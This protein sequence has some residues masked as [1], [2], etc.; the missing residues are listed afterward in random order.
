MTEPMAELEVRGRS[1]APIVETPKA[2]RRGLGVGKVAR[3]LGSGS[4]GQ[5]ALVMWGTRLALFV[6]V[7]GSWQL[8]ASN[9]VID[10]SFTGQPNEILVRFWQ[11]IVHGQFLGQLGFTLEATL[12][13]FGLGS[14]AAVLFAIFLNSNQL[15]DNA[16]RPY[17]TA[18]NSVPRIALVP[19][20]IMW[21]GLGT[22]AAVAV[23][24]SFVFFV[25][26]A[27]TLAGLQS[28]QRDH[29][30]MSR[31]FLCGRWRT[32]ATFIWPTAL[33][34]IVAG[35]QLGLVYSFLGVVGQEMLSGNVGVGA[36]LEESASTFHINTFFAGLLALVVLTVVIAQLMKAAES[37]LTRWKKAEYRGL[38][39]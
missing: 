15:A 24:V 26:L 6:V 31:L 27:N 3:T 5:S 35:L 16:T 11:G 30:V 23:A 37:R 34:A 4:W 25:V 9:K 22:V 17:L 20:F 29:L 38:I 39:G 10:P 7:F 8:L 2:G 18:A 33:P 19:L 12:I 32:F 14:A 13:A 21:F 1:R 36:S 28:V